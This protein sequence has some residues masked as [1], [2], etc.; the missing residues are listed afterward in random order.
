MTADVDSIA[1]VSPVAGLAPPRIQANQHRGCKGDGVQKH[2]RNISDDGR[3]R[4]SPRH[5]PDNCDGGGAARRDKYDEVIRGL[6][7][8]GA[9]EGHRIRGSEALRSRSR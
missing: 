3:P 1:T 5:D 8:V 9:A 6:M 2:A 4:L 7:V